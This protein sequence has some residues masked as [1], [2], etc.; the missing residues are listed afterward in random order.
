MNKGSLLSDTFEELVE[1]GK[2]TTQKTGGAV[3]TLTVGMA[4]KAGES[5]VGNSATADVADQPE[6]TGERK[7]YTELNS[8]RIEKNLRQQDQEEMNKVRQRLY[9]HFNRYKEEEKKATAALQRI[10]SER[11]QRQEQE[12]AEKKKALEEKQKKQELVVP[13][14][15]ERKSIFSAKKIAKR[16]QMETRVGSGKQ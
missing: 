14:G 8:Q 16:S 13:R 11:K 10:E 5:A 12:E 1:L 4:K 9:E 6:K 7:N 3:K 2:S 15:K